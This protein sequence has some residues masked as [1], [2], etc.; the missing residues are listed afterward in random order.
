MTN[1]DRLRGLRGLLPADGGSLVVFDLEWNQSAY[2]SNPL[3][4]HEIIEI[5]ACR[6]SPEGAEEATFSVLVKPRLYR[7]VDRHIKKVTGITEEELSGGLPFAEAFG[8]FSAFCGENPQL[9]A[10]GRDDFPVLRRNLGYHRIPLALNPPLDAQLVF[11]FTHFGDSHR[12]MNLHAAMEETGTEREVP[13]HRA[14]FDA[15]CT[16]ALLPFISEEAE[17]LPA[18]KKEELLSI[19]DRE[20]RVASAFQRS[21]LTRFARREEALTDRAIT[22]LPCPVCERETKFQTAWF[23]SGKDR[24]DAVGLCREHG[25]CEGQMHLR[26]SAAGTLSMTQRVYPCSE[27]EAEGVEEAYRRFLAIPPARRRNRLS[28]EEALAA[29]RKEKQSGRS[30]GTGADV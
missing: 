1:T 25:L 15:E 29:A 30:P 4:P 21:R 28:M 7:K 13:A 19:L 9:V 12:Q 6:L 18:D 26:R 20:R 10:W 11:G 24:Y 22:A 14:V 3:M 16:A 5:G 17:A 2:A 8:A 27:K 23:D